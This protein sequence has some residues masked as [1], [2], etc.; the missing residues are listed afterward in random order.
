MTPE[1]EILWEF[2]KREYL[3]HGAERQRP[4]AVVKG[5][6]QLTAH[7]IDM[8]VSP[9]VQMGLLARGEF[10]LY[11]TDDKLSAINEP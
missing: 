8:G 7:E 4:T 5:C 9:L 3:L 11:L 1:A 2:F 6:E 10:D